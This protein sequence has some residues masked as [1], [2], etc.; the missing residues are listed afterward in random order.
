MSPGGGCHS[1]PWS[2]VVICFQTSCLCPESSRNADLE[3]AVLCL[4]SFRGTRGVTVHLSPRDPWFADHWLLMVWLVAAPFGISGLDVISALPVLFSLASS[5]WE[6]CPLKCS[7]GCDESAL[8]FLWFWTHPVFLSCLPTLTEL[9]V[10]GYPLQVWVGGLQPITFLSQS[11][12]LFISLYI[13]LL[14]KTAIAQGVLRL[15]KTLKIT[16]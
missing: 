6:I 14:S 2:L 8:P 1:F 9:E 11:D 12:A 10:L 13:E 16:A 4:T 3:T 7:V 5:A 15:F